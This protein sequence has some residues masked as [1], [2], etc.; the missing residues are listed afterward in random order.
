MIV[1]DLLVEVDM[2]VLNET[3]RSTDPAE[4]ATERLPLRIKLSQG[5]ISPEAVTSL[6]FSLKDPG[7]VKRKGGKL[8]NNLTCTF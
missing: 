7:V 2:L 6:Q 1:V 3:V 5:E 4:V 8:T